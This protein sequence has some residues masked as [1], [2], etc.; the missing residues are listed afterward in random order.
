MAPSYWPKNNPFLPIA[1][2]RNR[3]PAAAFARRADASA[4]AVV[5]FPYAMGRERMQHLKW[6]TGEGD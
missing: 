4:I 1:R 6:W 3:L 5:L 2:A